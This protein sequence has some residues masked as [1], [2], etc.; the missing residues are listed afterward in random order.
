[1]VRT[2]NIPQSTLYKWWNAFCAETGQT[3]T[4]RHALEPDREAFHAWMHAHQAAEAEERARKEAEAQAKRRQQDLAD[5]LAFLATLAADYGRATV[6]AEVI[7]VFL[8]QE[9]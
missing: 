1:M 9:D 2:T 8:A 7:D 6:I 3:I 4:P 5:A